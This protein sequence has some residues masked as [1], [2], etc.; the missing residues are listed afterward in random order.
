MA[1]Q[2]T[3]SDTGKGGDEGDPSSTRRV[4]RELEVAAK[5]A[6]R[7]NPQLT[8]RAALATVLRDW[9]GGGKDRVPPGVVREVRDKLLKAQQRAMYPSQPATIGSAVATTSSAASSH[10]H[11]HHQH[12]HPTSAAAGNSIGGAAGVGAS[13]ATQPPS[14]TSG[15]SST[16]APPSPPPPPPPP[17][18]IT[19]AAT[20]TAVMVGAALVQ[21]AA[22]ALVHADSATNYRIVRKQLPRPGTRA[23]AS[24]RSADETLVCTLTAAQVESLQAS[25]SV[26]TTVECQL[27]R[28]YE[29][30]VQ[31]TC[32]HNI[33]THSQHHWLTSFSGA[34]VTCASLARC[35]S[36]VPPLLPPRLMCP[37]RLAA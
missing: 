34:Q 28:V 21:V 37:V 13:T 33:H 32:T 24:D 35:T 23:R 2:A 36:V 1:S 22:T 25:G 7:R 27:G 5:V 18:T 10:H 4:A 12:H 20:E 26:D 6:R 11:H 15:G 17:P 8:V 16:L 30:A 31:C 29:F 3:T 14:A 9:R 19:V